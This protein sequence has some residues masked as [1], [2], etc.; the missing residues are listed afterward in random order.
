MLPII[1]DDNEVTMT[2]FDF[3]N[4]VINPTRDRFG[5]KPVANDK[6]LKRVIDEVGFTENDKMSFTQ[7]GHFKPTSYFTLTLEHMT[8]VGMRESKGVRRSI[9]NKLKELSTP[10]PVTERDQLLLMAQTVIKQQE[11]I[12]LLE[13]TKAHI[14]DKRTATLMNKASQDAKKIKKLENQLQDVGTYQSL[15]ASKTP[16]RVD[17]EM[18]NNVQSWRLLKQLSSDMQLPP[19][20]VKCERYGVVLAYHVDVIARF[21]DKYL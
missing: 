14:N 16:Q 9:L 3:L 20:K 18:K 8:L 11:E 19:K 10:K 12:K 21:K 13:Q 17:T 5:E 2:S 4:N 15:A 7:K 1:Q 6:F